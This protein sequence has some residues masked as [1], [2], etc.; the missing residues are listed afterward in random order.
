[1]KL[2]RSDAHFPYR[3]YAA[4]ATRYRAPLL[5]KV[6]RVVRSA[7]QMHDIWAWFYVI[8]MLLMFLL[9]DMIR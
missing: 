2:Y 8:V 1:M 6:R 3:R 7:A 4:D 5:R 9:L